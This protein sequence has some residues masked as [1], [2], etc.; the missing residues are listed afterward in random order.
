MGKLPAQPLAPSSF[1]HLTSYQ[2]SFAGWRKQ[3]SPPLKNLLQFKANNVHPYRRATLYQDSFTL[4]NH[5][6][7]K[8]VK[9]EPHIE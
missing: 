7:E 6:P 9:R 2:A 1:C 3:T 4:P 5:K 8:A